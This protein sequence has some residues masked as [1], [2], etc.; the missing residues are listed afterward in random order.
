MFHACWDG[1]WLVEDIA[2]WRA[3]HRACC[4]RV[5]GKYKGRPDGCGSDN[6]E[7]MVRTE[8]MMQPR[9]R[10]LI[11]SGTSD[12]TLRQPTS[13]DLCH[14]R[15]GPAIKAAPFDAAKPHTWGSRPDVI[16]DYFAIAEPWKQTLE[17][18]TT[19]HIPRARSSTARPAV[20]AHTCLFTPGGSVGRGIH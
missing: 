2:S 19:N 17:A 6:S 9:T 14:C 13:P 7:R 8:Q 12:L 20:A 16:S 3:N 15:L 4:T 10:S 11:G 1:D 18:G 5:L